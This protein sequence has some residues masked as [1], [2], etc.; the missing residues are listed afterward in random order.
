MPGDFAEFALDV[1]GLDVNAPP[2]PLPK[3]VYDSKE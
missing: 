2:P 1:H 3:L